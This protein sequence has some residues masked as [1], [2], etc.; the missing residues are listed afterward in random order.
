M[1]SITVLPY[2]TD[3]S[4]LISSILCC[5]LGSQVSTVFSYQT[6]NYKELLV[7]I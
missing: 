7:M 1:G 6:K 4:E 5:N 3:M 2:I